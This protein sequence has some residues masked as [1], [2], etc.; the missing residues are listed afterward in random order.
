MTTDIF[1]LLK[2]C[3]LT[4]LPQTKITFPKQQLSRISLCSFNLHEHMHTSLHTVATLS[5]LSQSP[6]PPGLI[7]ATVGQWGGKRL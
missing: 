1:S 6:P 3:K 2:L 4:K 5:P 7:I